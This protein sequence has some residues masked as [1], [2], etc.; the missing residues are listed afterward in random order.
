MANSEQTNYRNDES[1]LNPI[2]RYKDFLWLCLDNWY[3]FV[4]SL[5]VVLGFATARILRTPPRYTRMA[6]I[7]IK[8]TNMTRSRSDL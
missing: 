7:L 2:E 1:Q 4:I 6:T 3:W 5:V 8:E